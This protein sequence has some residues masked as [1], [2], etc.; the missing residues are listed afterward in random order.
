MSP[1]C[2]AK[3]A[4][5]TRCKNSAIE[6]TKRCAKHPV[7]K[8]TR[9]AAPTRAQARDAARAA[10]KAT[11]V[12]ELAR[13][14]IVL[15]ACEAAGVG[16]TA[17]YE[18]YEADPDFAAAWDA[19][20]ETST[21]RMEAEA[22]R[23]GIEGVEKPL[24]VGG[25]LVSKRAL[26]GLPPLGDEDDPINDIATIR[27]YSDPLLQTMLKANRPEKY[28]DRMEVTGKGGGA[29]VHEF[30]FTTVDEAEAQI[31]AL[32]AEFAGIVAGLAQD[33][34]GGDCEG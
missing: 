17:A 5:G 21:D 7:Q 34:D 25:H 20:L 13:R 10:Q 6:G 8:R 29:I 18:W 32:D 26:Q 9:R 2:T 33:G 1:R 28:R 16:R 3:T 11:F 23:R 14:G 27:E 19:A 22:W 30:N 31:D 15:H 12:A 4:A 24:V